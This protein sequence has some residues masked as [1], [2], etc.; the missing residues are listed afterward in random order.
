MVALHTGEAQLRDGDYYGGTLNR[1]AWIRGLAAGGEILLSHST[2]DLVVDVIAADLVLVALGEHEMKGLRR[3][4]LLYGIEGP[5][6]QLR[7][8]TSVLRTRRVSFPG[9]CRSR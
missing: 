9:T 1:A 5:G 2:H 4:E 7:D 6:L 3:T 8:S